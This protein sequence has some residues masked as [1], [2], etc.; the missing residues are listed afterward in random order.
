[1][2]KSPFEKPPL[3]QGISP[4]PLVAVPGDVGCW[5]LIEGESCVGVAVAGAFVAAAAGEAFDVH[6]AEPFGLDSGMLLD[7]A[8]LEEVTD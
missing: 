1:V 5:T 8:S 3:P 2:T 6:E 4:Y 7:G